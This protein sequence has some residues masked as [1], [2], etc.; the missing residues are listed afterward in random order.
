M[1]RVIEGAAPATPSQEYTPPYIWRGESFVDPFPEYQ[2]TDNADLY[3]CTG[4]DQQNPK[5]G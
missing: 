3:I 2:Q 1:F 4:T 5:R